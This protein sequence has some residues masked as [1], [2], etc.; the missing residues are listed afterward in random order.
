MGV[1]IAVIEAGAPVAAPV[2]PETKWPGMNDPETYEA[3]IKPFACDTGTC[4]SFIKP[5]LPTNDAPDR[6]ADGIERVG[7]IWLPEED[8]GKVLSTSDAGVDV[9]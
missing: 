5:L 7:K 9:V 3:G 2:Y 6:S 4:C 8:A 1:G